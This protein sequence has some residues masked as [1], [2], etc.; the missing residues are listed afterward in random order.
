MKASMKALYCTT[1]SAATTCYDVESYH[2]ESADAVSI[3]EI[4]VQRGADFFMGRVFPVAS[5]LAGYLRY[6]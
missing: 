6:W 1:K 3:A 2:G 4:Y 5:L